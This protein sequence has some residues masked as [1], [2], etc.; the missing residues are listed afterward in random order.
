MGLNAQVMLYTVG[1]MGPAYTFG[2]AMT[3]VF[4]S[5][6][7]FLIITMTGLRKWLYEGIPD[8]VKAAIPVGIGL[9]IAFIGFV[10]ANIV[11]DSPATL[12]TSVQIN[13]MYL[14]DENG[15]KVVFNALVCFIGLFTVIILEHYKIKGAI[16]IG[17]FFILFYFFFL[18]YIYIYIY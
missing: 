11:V 12:V 3:I 16:L 17:Y 6:V 18:Y 14:A 15:R 13:S 2:G 7:I 5:G 9:F 8:A 10:D 1:V 4:V